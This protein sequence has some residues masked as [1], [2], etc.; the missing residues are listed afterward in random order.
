VE[1]ARRPF[2]A[3]HT[4]VHV[5]LRTRKEV[6]RLRRRVG[7]RAVREALAVN[8]GRVERFRIVHLSIQ[9]N[10]IHLVVEARD[11]VEL[12]RGMRSF[13]ISLAR[14]VNRRLGRRGALLADRYHARALTS[15]KEVRHGLSY[16]LNNWRRHR[17]HEG[18]AGAPFDF[19][20]SAR[21]FDG[22]T[23]T[24]RSRIN[25]EDELLPTAFA[26]EW[27]LT[28]GWRR[29]RLVSPTEIPG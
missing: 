17:E 29:H 28:T 24:W 8:L 23:T 22:W 27:L 15:P 12:T 19:Y 6:G 25:A 16:V 18:S 21:A 20:S 5:T 11:R 1:H 4:P 7:Y 13:S 10:H 26:R 9:H 14:Q 3:R 2:L